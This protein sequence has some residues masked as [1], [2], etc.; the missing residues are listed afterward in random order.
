MGVRRISEGAVSAQ[1]WQPDVSCM[2]SVQAKYVTKLPV[3]VVSWQPNHLLMIGV[4]EKYVTKRGAGIG[5]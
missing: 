3:G 1:S 4:Q 2:I 5:S